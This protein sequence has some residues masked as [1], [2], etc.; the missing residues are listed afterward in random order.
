MKTIARRATVKVDVPEDQAFNER[1]A[2]ITD[3]I[4]GLPTLL[5]ILRGRD[6]MLRE[7]EQAA[8]EKGWNGWGSLAAF[9]RER[10]L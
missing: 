4:D 7:A 6:Q 10:L 1:D 3:L 9:I 5:G 2:L 8:R